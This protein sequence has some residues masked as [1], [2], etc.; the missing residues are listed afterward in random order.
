MPTFALSPQERRLAGFCRFFAVVY[1]LAALLVAAVPRL[2]YVIASLGQPS[3]LSPETRFWSL[4]AAALE[5]ASAVAC[6]VVAG[7]PRGRRH[8]LLPVVAAKLTTTLLASLHLLHVRG[9]A[10][11]SLVAIVLT[12]LPIFLLTLFVYRSS[13]PGVHSV[14][15]TQAPPPPGGTAAPVQLGV[16]PKP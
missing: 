10:A 15:P 2:A 9:P 12:D 3:D 4:L 11:R 13:A 7:D 16:G 5:V 1:L 14:R 8:A 6:A